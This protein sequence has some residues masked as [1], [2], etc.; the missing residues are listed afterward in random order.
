[1]KIENWTGVRQLIVLIVLNLFFFQ[2]YS[3]KKWAGRVGVGGGGW[4]AGANTIC[5]GAGWNFMG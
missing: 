1:M 3:V 2:M 5:G 4:G